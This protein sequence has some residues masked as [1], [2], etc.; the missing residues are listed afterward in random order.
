LFTAPFKTSVIYAGNMS[1]GKFVGRNSVI[2]I[3]IGRVG[4]HDEVNVEIG[5]C[6]PT[7]TY[8]SGCATP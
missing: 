3:N 4:L 5:S 7:Q 8:V 6:K 2:I 1:E